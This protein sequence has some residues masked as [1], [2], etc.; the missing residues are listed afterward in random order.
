[1][2]SKQQFK[3]SGPRLTDIVMTVAQDGDVITTTKQHVPDDVPLPT[4]QEADLVNGGANMEAVS[5]IADRTNERLL[6]VSTKAHTTR[7]SSEFS[8]EFGQGVTRIETVRAV[9]ADETYVDEADATTIDLRHDHVSKDQVRRTE[10]VPQPSFAERRF[11]VY[12]EDLQMHVYE[13]RQFIPTGSNTFVAGDPYETSPSGFPGGFT[14]LSVDLL[15]YSPT[16]EERVMRCLPQS[17]NALFQTIFE[18]DSIGFQ[19]PAIVEI[20][21]TGWSPSND[22][23]IKPPHVGV[24]Y[25]LLPHRNSAFPC[26]V[27]TDF[28]Q[29]PPPDDLPTRFSVISPGAASRVIPIPENSIH[30]D[31][32]FFET[33]PTVVGA[34]VEIFPASTPSPEDFDPLYFFVVDV[35]Q[36][37]WKGN[38]YIRRVTFVSP[39][40]PPEDFPSDY[41]VVNGIV[42]PI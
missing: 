42:I 33:T 38:I 3:N 5:L 15:H 1:M 31:F 19:V 20:L 12:D 16:I 14:V 23:T 32:S 27:R 22:F 25:T 37:I 40:T 21:D 10:L 28:Y 18:Y 34:Q 9:D 2:D 36:R 7:T 24:H 6:S 29:G 4:A 11:T 17:E 41:V 13:L 30:P 8:P 35:R 39:D 26:V